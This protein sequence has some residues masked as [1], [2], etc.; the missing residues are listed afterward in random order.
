MKKIITLILLVS[1]LLQSCASTSVGEVE[2]VG[3]VTTSDN[4]KFLGRF[5]GES[6]GSAFLGLFYFEEYDLRN[7]ALKDLLNKTAYHRTK[8]TK[9]INISY[10][11]K[12]WLFIIPF[13]VYGGQKVKISADMVEIKP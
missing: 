11:N 4:V 1:V 7:E 13:P 6:S 2:Q 5:S 8:N 10:D 3:S 12:Y 9:L